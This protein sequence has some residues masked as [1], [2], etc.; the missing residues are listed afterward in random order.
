MTL[1]HCGVCRTLLGSVA[2]I[3]LI[4]FVASGKTVRPS[5][6]TSVSSASG[7][8]VLD[9]S[10][11]G[12]VG[13]GIAD[14]GPALQRA[15]DG[16]CSRGRWNSAHS[17][18]SLSDR[19]AGY[20]RLC[21]PRVRYSPHSVPALHARRA[22]RLVVPNIRRLDLTSD[23]IPATGESECDQSSK[24]PSSLDRTHQLFWPT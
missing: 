20:E 12:A 10:D 7:D 24:R 6:G 21:G 11:F 14:D 16:T 5:H 18:W 3:L 4:G 15:L 23:I 2:L 22:P 13:N 19:D 9:L 8:A 17:G 1:N